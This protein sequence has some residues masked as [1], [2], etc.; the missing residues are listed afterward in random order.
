MNGFQIE[1]VMIVKGMV[2]SKSGEQSKRHVNHS[3]HE[4]EADKA[5][6]REVV[7]E[8]IF[9]EHPSVLCSAY[10]KDCLWVLFS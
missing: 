5:L 1:N 8:N 7:H 9:V 10:L 4:T 3:K 2:V 6:F